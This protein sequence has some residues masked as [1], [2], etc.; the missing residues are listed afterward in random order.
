[1]W[2]G[3]WAGW[4]G[5]G[6]GGGGL[7]NGEVG[8]G[9]KRG[10]TKTKKCLKTIN[11]R[12]APRPF[13]VLFSPGRVWIALRIRAVGFFF[14]GWG[15]EFRVVGGAPVPPFLAGGPRGKRGPGAGGVDIRGGG[16]MRQTGKTQKP[17]NAKNQGGGGNTEGD[18][19]GGKSNTPYEMPPQTTPKP[20]TQRGEGGR[21]GAQGKVVGEG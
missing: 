21:R 14:G 15:A 6:G 18:R 3:G 7:G 10:H 16:A 20:H 4:G 19:G 1:V 8:W 11:V 5:G 9:D 13:F 2:V 12:G 17:N